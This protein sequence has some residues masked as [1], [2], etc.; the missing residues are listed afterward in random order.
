MN[1]K[2]NKN[3]RLLLDLLYIAIIFTLTNLIA[4]V[5]D[6]ELGIFDQ[7]IIVLT[8]STIIKY[9]TKYPILLL[10]AL[11]LGFF[12]LLF[13]NTYRFPIVLSIL[14]KISKV[15]SNLIEN[16]RMRGIIAKENMLFIYSFIVILISAYTSIVIYRMKN[17]FFLIPIYLLIFLIYWY[18]F[19]DKAYN[20]TAIFLFLFL[21]LLGFTKY[22]KSKFN[23]SKLFNRWI[24]ISIIYSIIIISIAFLIPKSND[25]INWPWLQN[26]V[27]NTFPMIEDL[28][29]Y[30]DY[31]RKTAN[32]DLF[33]FSTSGFSDENTDSE[34]GGPLVES[35][36]KIMTVRTSSPLYLR[37]NTNHVYTGRSWINMSYPLLEY[38]LRQDFSG[39]LEEEKDKY[40]IEDQIAI[41]F[42]S[43]TS[44]TLFTPYKASAINSNKDFSIIIDN[45]GIVTS[46]N[47]IYKNEGY[48]VAYLKPLPYESLLLNR[49]DKRKSE[50][51]DL[52][53]YLQLPSNFNGE[54]ITQRTIDLT[55]SLVEGIE[56]DY[57]KAI[58]IQSYLRNNY[59]YSLDVPPLPDDK[60]FIDHFLFEQ[61]EGYCTYYASS[62]AIMLRL[63]DI[64]TRYVEGYI[65][66]E[67]ISENE[68][69]VRQKHAH[70][71]VEAFIEP[72]G[73]MSFEPTSAYSSLENLEKE[74]DEIKPDIKED[75]LPE[76]ENIT[77]EPQKEIDTPLE[78][79]N[80]VDAD[81][82][83]IKNLWKTIIL[84]SILIILL[85]IIIRIV[86]RFSRYHSKDKYLD[87]LTDKEKTIYLYKD[88]LDILY[89]LGF[90]IENGE[91]HF[92]YSDRIA[93][94]FIDL[95]DY[96]IKDITSIF[97]KIKYSN[98]KPNI[99]DV[100]SLLNYKDE[101]DNRLKNTLGKTNYLYRKYINIYFKRRKEI[102]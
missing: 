73:W 36:R 49:I 47:G 56:D 74:E 17:I 9:F 22:K 6:L 11:I 4:N 5:I 96:G 70:A 95:Q 93:Y 75:V 102:P 94:K 48:V 69:Q 78:D 35:E 19:I 62:M 21:I 41:T 53:L 50:L 42:D 46:Q 91:T 89:I 68:Y 71:W 88:I 12:I 80:I 32:A 33:N 39:L 51:M 28:R 2:Y 59:R 34:L 7:F 65:V 1:K 45:D 43:F 97:V 86:R 87:S 16:L 66:N 30:K 61:K 37:G 23:S 76:K 58:T 90:P 15:F 26:K 52:D 81:T 27:Y 40:F 54:I 3:R 60:D 99:K 31:N 8:I 85:F 84:S 24:R 57:Q 10:I 79:N 82:N 55:K 29:Y 20:F 92:D 100:L 38:N 72:V 25:Y 67:K 44:K 98:M 18:S 77:K 64:P 83:T 101:L 14:D 13:V 63:E